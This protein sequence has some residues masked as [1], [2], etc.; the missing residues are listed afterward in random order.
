MIESKLETLDW[1][2]LRDFAVVADCG[3]LSAAARRLGVSQATLT[4]RMAAL[5]AHLGSEVL[6]R[7]SR[8]VEL[9]EVGEALLEPVRLMR[10]QVDEVELSAAGRDAQL[11]GPVRISATEGIAF[12]FLIPALRRFSRDHPAIEL[13]LDVR[14][15]NANL[16]RRE[17]DIAVRLGR[18]RQQHQLVARRVA[19]LSLGLYGSRDYLRS[20][21]PPESPEDLERHAM[22]A[23]DDSVVDTHVGRRAEDLLGRGTVVFRSSSIFAQL[24]AVRAGLG[25]GVVSDF[26][27][28]E[29]PELV[30]VLPETVHRLSIWMVTHPGLR[31]SARI[32]AVYDLLVERFEAERGRLLLEPPPAGR[33][34]APGEAVG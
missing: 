14:N 5:E 20:R 17:A 32:R 13:Q 23:F 16:L 8:G 11:R 6:R 9:T 31:R 34:P 15:R 27:A 7:T 2:W 26:I 33:R 4:R 28:C 29:I 21:P 3:S 12:R 1:R 22:V 10:E 18:P 30:R 25:L 19:E 24:E